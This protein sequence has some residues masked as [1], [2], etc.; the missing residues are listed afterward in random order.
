MVRQDPD[1]KYHKIVESK[2]QKV[3]EASKV[4]P[5][6]QKKTKL[7]KLFFGKSL[8]IERYNILIKNTDD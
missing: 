8:Y 2:E 6:I 7:S 5:F 3:D 1:W 4:L